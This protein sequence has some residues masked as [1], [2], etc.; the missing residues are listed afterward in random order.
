MPLSLGRR[1]ATAWMTTVMGSLM[2]VWS[3]LVSIQTVGLR[4]YSPVAWGS[5][6]SV[7]LWDHAL[8]FAI[9]KMMIVM[10]R[11]MRISLNLVEIP[12]AERGSA[13][14]LRALLSWESAAVVN[15]QR[16]SAAIRSMMTATVGLMRAAWLARR[17]SGLTVAPLRA[18]VV[19]GRVNAMG[20]E[21]GVPV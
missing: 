18:L 13:P 17:E 11:W 12:P 16:R 14:V 5:G 1:S 19:L 3:A 7:T 20:R 21:S 4:G 6:P 10:M 9:T 2:R 15:P 8:R